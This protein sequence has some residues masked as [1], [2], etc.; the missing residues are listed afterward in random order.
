[1][2]LTS[3]VTDPVQSYLNSTQTIKFTITTKNPLMSTD[4]ILLSYPS[5]YTYTGV[6]PTTDS[7]CSE[8]SSNYNCIPLTTNNLTVKITGNWNNQTSFSFHVK[9]YRS[10]SLMQYINMT[11]YFLVYTKQVD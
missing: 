2:T 4:F 9:N 5:V 1:M 10:P 8:P 7:I 11:T 6:I 3:S